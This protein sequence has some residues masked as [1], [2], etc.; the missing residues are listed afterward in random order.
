MASI[1]S[2]LTT[3]RSSRP[4]QQTARLTAEP[5]FLEMSVMICTHFLMKPSRVGRPMTFSAVLIALPFH[6]CCHGSRI[7]EYYSSTAW[8]CDLTRRPA[9]TPF[10]HCQAVSGH[11]KSP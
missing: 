1:G 10:H 11:A 4:I 3:C 2:Q 5:V 9:G 6:G 7:R 8:Q